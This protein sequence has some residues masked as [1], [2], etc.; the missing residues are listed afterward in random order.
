MS[1][2]ALF[3]SLSYD[4]QLI[5]AKIGLYD[6]PIHGPARRPAH[7]GRESFMGQPHGMADQQ[8]ADLVDRKIAEHELMRDQI[9]KELTAGKEQFLP[10]VERLGNKEGCSNKNNTNTD[11]TYDWFNDKFLMIL[12]FVL[13]VFCIV[14]YIN[15]QQL[16]SGVQDLLNSLR[17]VNHNM[18]TLYQ[19]SQPVTGVIAQ[20][21][22]QQALQVPP[23]TQATV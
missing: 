11:G 3:N 19:Q 12:L 14:Q 15:Q 8:L 16:V 9:R 22:I 18:P 7:G 4:E 20:V 6:V 17:M 1:D 13:V 21:P 5:S 23:V 10:N 2:D